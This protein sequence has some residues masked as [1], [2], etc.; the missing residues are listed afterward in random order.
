MGTNKATI[1]PDTTISGFLSD[2]SPFPTSIWFILWNADLRPKPYFDGD[3]F[4]WHAESI[5]EKETEVK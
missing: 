1:Q 5:A 2:T 3:L 4:A